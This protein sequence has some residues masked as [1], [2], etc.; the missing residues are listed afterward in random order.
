MK[1]MAEI[2][3]LINE[4]R[5]VKSNLTNYQDLNQEIREM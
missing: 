1:N 3:E 5:K 2:S 4:R